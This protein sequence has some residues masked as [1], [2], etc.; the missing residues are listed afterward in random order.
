MGYSKI[1]VSNQK[2]ES[3]SVQRAIMHHPIYPTVPEKWSQQGFLIKDYV[4]DSDLLGSMNS[5]ERYGHTN[6]YRQVFICLI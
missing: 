5:I 3:I 6:T 1:I 4:S 2:E